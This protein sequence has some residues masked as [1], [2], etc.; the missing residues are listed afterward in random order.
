MRLR[1]DRSCWLA[2][3]ILAIAAGSP[4]RAAPPADF[5]SVAQALLPSVVTIETE[6]DGH[7]AA[8][9][10]GESFGGVARGSGS[11]FV[12][13]AD[14][15]ILTN[16]HVV[17]DATRIEVELHN[18][19]RFIAR[20]LGADETTDIA[21]LQIDAKGLAPVRFADSNAARPG[22]WVAAIGAP[23]GLRHT[24]TVGVI[25]AT[26]RT[27]GSIT[28]HLQTDAIIHPGNS[29][30]PLVDR[31]G[32]VLGVSSRILSGATGIGFA[33]AA[34]AARRVIGELRANGRVTRGWIGAKA[35]TLTHAIAQHLGRST[36][37]GVLIANVTPKSPAETGRLQAGDIVL[38]LDGVAPTSAEHFERV[39][40]ESAAGREIKIS[41][42]RGGT[43]YA[44]SLAVATEPPAS[45]R[46]KS[47]SG[48]TYADRELLG[49]G[50]R[51]AS[52]ELR[53]ETGYRGPGT[54]IIVRVAPA[55]PADRAGLYPGLAVLRADGVRVER[56][57]DLLQAVADRAAL[58]L[59]ED[60]EGDTG[61]VLVTAK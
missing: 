57:R 56:P 52:S 21:V 15:I 24:V 38:T 59:L 54:V 39:I 46:A 19:K 51:E 55:S 2:L 30:G 10:F 41:I 36:N 32:A 13:E 14:G 22:Q 23:F 12:I 42:W 45:E 29:G 3:S 7:S 37:D 26:K 18:G 49:I 34:N 11:G 9:F 28:E 31:T 17:E 8:G 33:I 60:A 43:A 1:F 48:D 53:E 16:A 47:A 40:T 50:V 27:A 58:L 61:F 20:L 44:G 6:I 25:S 5:E 4:A 35:Q